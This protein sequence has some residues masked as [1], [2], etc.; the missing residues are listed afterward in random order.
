MWSSG[1][2]KDQI[3]E[4]LESYVFEFSDSK[5]ISNFVYR[6]CFIFGAVG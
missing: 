4:L 6:H 5:I 3:C 2:K 1:N